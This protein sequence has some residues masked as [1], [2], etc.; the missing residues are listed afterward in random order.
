[1]KVNYTPA[2]QAII[3]AVVS[4]GESLEKMYQ[5]SSNKV[6]EFNNWPA[7]LASMVQSHCPT[8]EVEVV[9]EQLRSW[10][11]GYCWKA[12]SMKPDGW[13][14]T[15]STEHTFK[16]REAMLE[17]AEKHH[18]EIPVECSKEGF[19]D[20]DKAKT[21]VTHKVKLADDFTACLSYY[22]EGMPTTT[23]RVETSVSHHIVCDVK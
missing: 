21:K 22:R 8:A 10:E 13:E 6:P 9:R 23:C 18:V 11:L 12:I 5:S 7:G 1:M 17:W 16:S 15:F 3:E 4:L 2:V 19:I 14:V 20:D